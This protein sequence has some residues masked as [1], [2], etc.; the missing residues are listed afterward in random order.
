MRQKKKRKGRKVMSAKSI[1]RFNEYYNWQFE[2]DGR[3]AIR[4]WSRKRIQK[5]QGFNKSY[6][7][8]L[9]YTFHLNTMKSF[10]ENFNFMVILQMVIAAA[11]VY[12][13]D[14]YDIYY[15]FSV[16]LFVS[17]IVFPLAFSINTDF[18]RREKVLDDLANFK[19]SSM[20]WFFCM[21]EWKLGAGL[22][23]VWMN[24]IQKKLHSIMF[25]LREYLLTSRR[26]RRNIIARY[27]Y[28]DYSDSSQL[29]E[30]VRDSKLPANPAL[31]SR[32]YHL[33][34]AICLSFERLRVVREYRSPR[35]IRSFNKVLVLLLPIILCPYFVSLSRAQGANKWGPYFIAVL[36]AAVFG[37]LQGVQDKLDDPFDGMSEDDINLDTIDEWTFNSLD[38]AAKRNF[39][40]FGRFVVSNSKDK[41]C[42]QRKG[43]RC[44][45]DEF[46][47]KCGGE[48]QY[49]KTTRSKSIVE[50]LQEID[51]DDTIRS[52]EFKNRKKSFL[53]RSLRRKPSKMNS[54]SVLYS[55]NGKVPSYSQSSLR[56]RNNT[57][58]RKVS[59]SR[60]NNQNCERKDD[61]TTSTTESDSESAHR[62]E[63]AAKQP[64]LMPKLK[65]EEE[66]KP[67]APAPA[68]I[69][70]TVSDCDEN[71]LEKQT[72]DSF[73]EVIVLE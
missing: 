51:G 57:N 16:A 62:N 37:A 45:L 11:S 69:T 47:E 71:S 22:D 35:S 48:Q 18:Q 14:H 15:N 67:P 73:H 70:L 10:V 63:S 65:E 1:R 50:F 72:D 3:E 12:L 30:R 52:N 17:P 54:D 24:E 42:D 7:G 9:V 33:L 53:K 68:A 5:M 49:K 34:N 21:R 25:N 55:T 64:L 60:E 59:F 36:V 38:Y 32:S 6:Y 8:C 46:A 27:M 44:T 43:S 4:E 13:F 39:E 40:K 66:V 56:I 29:I 28:E 41:E 31:I 58:N 19:S 2:D 20:L 26:D 61:T 23:D